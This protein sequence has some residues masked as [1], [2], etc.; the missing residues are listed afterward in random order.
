[1]AEDRTRTSTPAL[2][3]VRAGGAALALLCSLKILV[4][5]VE[6]DL[7][8]TRAPVIYLLPI[9]VLVV[10]VVLCGRGRPAGVW[11]VAVVALTLLALFVVALIRSGVP[12]L[13]SDAVLVLAGIPVATAVLLAVPGA[14][15]QR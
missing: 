15:R 10:G 5:L 13:W 4:L 2:T 9:A 11:L 14:V 1:M 8:I 7:D 12:D 3:V 6:V